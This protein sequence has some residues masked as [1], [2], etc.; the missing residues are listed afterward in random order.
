LT[1]ANSEKTCQ[2]PNCVNNFKSHKTKLIHHNKFE[3]DC[4]KE[5]SFLVDLVGKFKTTVEYFIKTNDI[6]ESS[7]LGSK[8]Y[9]NL[10]KQYEETS[11]VILKKDQFKTIM[12]G[13]M[14]NF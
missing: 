11:A 3:P 10:K 9:Q 5:K 4:E 2:H 7:I 8:E 1:I 14:L 13:K 6:Q 12:E